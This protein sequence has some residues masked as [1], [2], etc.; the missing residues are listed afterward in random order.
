MVTEPLCTPLNDLD[1]SLLQPG[2]ILLVANPTDR[3]WIRYP[4]FWSHIGIVTERGVVDAARDPRGDAANSRPSWY[5][6]E[7]VPYYGYQV[8][9]DII[10][11]RVKCP[12]EVR[13]AA[14]RYA[15]SKIGFPYSSTYRQVAFSRRDT[16]HYSCA[17]LMWQAYKT[18]GIDLAPTPGDIEIAVLPAALAHSREVEVVGRGTRYKPIPC[19]PR[20]LPLILERLWFRHVLRA[21]IKFQVSGF[22]FRVSS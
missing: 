21:D 14:A 18:Q 16:S 9:Y 3:W 11:L 19:Q 20:Y 2:D 1:Y 6:V 5:S 8:A 15:D 10:A 13:L 12:P 4:V 22:E 17:S 7:A